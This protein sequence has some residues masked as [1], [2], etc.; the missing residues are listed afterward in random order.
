MEDSA[1]DPRLPGFPAPLRRL[2]ILILVA[3]VAALESGCALQLHSVTDPAA[4]SV[5]LDANAKVYG[6]GF[7]VKLKFFVDLT[8]ATGGTIEVDA[9]VVEL[10]AYR[11]GFPESAALSQ[12]WAYRQ[13]GRASMEGELFLESGK[14]LTVPI[15]PERDRP[16]QASKEFPLELLPAGEYQ[17]FATVNGKH[18]SP[19]LALRI[20]RPDLSRRGRGA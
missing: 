15:L 4:L 14:R 2:G 18:R 16:G 11:V 3:G 8:N 10:S 17:I 6:P 7:P 12:R 5:K 20:E 19:A 13:R 1:C 9:L